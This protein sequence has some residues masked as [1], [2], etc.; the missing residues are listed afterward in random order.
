MGKF[1]IFRKCWPKHK[2][3]IKIFDIGKEKID[4]EMNIIEMIK[5]IREV[6]IV[7]KHMSK[8]DPFIY[9]DIIADE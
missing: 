3:I 7:L 2:K 8:N 1:F 5:V 6:K 4:H 9:S